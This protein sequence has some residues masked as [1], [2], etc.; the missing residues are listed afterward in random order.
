M[1][2][3]EIYYFSGTGNSLHVASELQKRIPGTTLIPMASLVHSD[4]IKALGDKVGFVFPHYAS[5]LPSVVRAFL[6]KL[7]LVSATYLFAVVTRGG[8]GTFTFLELDEIL[9][10][11]GRL[12][13]SF[14]VITMPSGSDPL[15][16]GY[17]ERI[18]EERIQRL[19]GTMLAR[20]EQI[21]STV[22]HREPHRNE[23]TG[24]AEP[25]PRWLKPMLPFLERMTPALISLGKRVERQFEF[26]VDDTCTGCGVCAKVCLAERVDLANSRPVWPEKKA[27]HGCFAC[28][29]YC[30]ERSVQVK[31]SWYLKSYTTTN[32]RYHHPQVRA[33]DIARQ[34]ELH[35]FSG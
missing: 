3:T 31:S 17:A 30:P 28:L 20:L 13:D 2:S 32:G 12:L 23:D 6:E 7:D 15:V 21:R 16:K 29:N 25:P 27:C 14:F 33:R 19:E 5:S 9:Q 35:N 26:Y 1:M 8:T 11:Q 34:K 24:P 22:M 10:E 18:T 4:S